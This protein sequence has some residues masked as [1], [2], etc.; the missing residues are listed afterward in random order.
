[1]TKRTV[2]RILILKLSAL[3]DVIHTLPALTT[4][5]RHQPEADIAWLVE[6][7]AA[8][9][10]DGH[11]ALNRVLVLPRRVWSRD[12]REG[13]RMAAVRGFLAFARAFRTERFDLAIDFQGLAKSAVWMALA[14]SPRKAG[15]GRGLPRN[16]GA[17]LTLSERV[18]PGSPDRH[19]LDRGLA[20]LEGLGFPRLPLAYDLPVG[21][22]AEARAESLLREAG[23]AQGAAFVA[24]NPMTRWPT[25]DWEP[26][27]FAAVLDRLRAR[28]IP[29]VLT[30]GPGDREAHRR[31]PGGRG[32]RLGFDAG[33]P[34]RPDVAQGAGGGVPEGAGGVVD[35]HRTDAPGGRRG[36]AGGGV[37][38]ADGT[39]AH[40]PVRSR[41]HRAQVGAR[42]QSVLPSPVRDHAIRAARLHA[43]A[44][45]GRR[46]RGGGDGVAGTA[47]FG[48]GRAAPG[49][50]LRRLFSSNPNRG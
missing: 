40:R 30:G 24:V 33:P 11:P 42:V 5:R 13:R 29:V 7:A 20:L 14:R 22:E 47:R 19:A 27:R 38:R 31:H 25:K 46:G 10:L 28:G 12:S 15:F 1:V 23:L 2:V 37:V 36:N 6:D 17:W 26:A 21:A 16:E 35:G 4:L 39:L 48:G 50:V 18:P 45:G 49:I 44:G 8:D 9:L 34:G 32:P 3:G 43:A 41:P